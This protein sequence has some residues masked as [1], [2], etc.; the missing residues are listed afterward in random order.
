MWNEA[1]EIEEKGN[2]T[3]QKMNMM[4]SSRLSDCS[5]SIHGSLIPS[6]RHKLPELDIDFIL[7][8]YSLLLTKTIFHYCKHLSYTQSLLYVRRR[9][10][11]CVFVL[12]LFLPLL[13]VT[14]TAS[15]ATDEVVCGDG[16]CISSSKKCDREY[17]CID[18]ADERDCG[19]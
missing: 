13:R 19:K 7:F 3:N 11:V 9:V 2:S 15:C 14:L 6:K 12:C 10:C 18:G 1:N 4:G 8:D 17:D 5:F 16:R